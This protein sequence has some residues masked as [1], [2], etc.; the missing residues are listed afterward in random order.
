MGGWVYEIAD[1]GNGLDINAMF[2]RSQAPWRFE[3]EIAFDGGVPPQHIKGAYEYS[4]GTWT[5]GYVTNPGFG[6]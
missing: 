6:G 2:K 5:G 3:K 1:P 4:G